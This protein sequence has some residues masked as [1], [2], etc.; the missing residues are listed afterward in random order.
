MENGPQRG[1]EVVEGESIDG[2]ASGPALGSWSLLQEGRE[3]M[4]RG[5]FLIIQNH[6]GSGW[7]WSSNLPMVM[8]DIHGSR[9]RKTVDKTSQAVAGGRVATWKLCARSKL[10]LWGH[11]GLSRG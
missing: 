1:Y 10:H 2:T 6:V 7:F 4:A 3:L 11:P 5:L 8:F 9:G